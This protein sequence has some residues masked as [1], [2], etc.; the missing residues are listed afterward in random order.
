MDDPKWL[1]LITIGLI[2]ASL[3]VGYLLFTGAFASHKAKKVVVPPSPSP[4]ADAAVLP[5]QTSAPFTSSAYNAIADRTQ[6]SVQ[7]L[8]NT[9]FPVGLLGAFSVGAVIAGWGLRKFPM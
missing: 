7:T 8:P 5:L 4:V 2:L 9:G 3:V 6:G 1:R